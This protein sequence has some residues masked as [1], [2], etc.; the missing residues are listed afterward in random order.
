MHQL[1]AA[2]GPLRSELLCMPR[3]STYA[4]P[5]LHAPAAALLPPAVAGDRTVLR[6]ARRLLFGGSRTTAEA[7]ARTLLGTQDSYG[8]VD[9][10]SR[11]R[12]R[13]F[14]GAQTLVSCSATL[15][16]DVLQVSAQPCMRATPSLS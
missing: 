16:S 2:E 1:T 9:G 13:L 8:G 12:Y 10:V 4:L 15:C 3:P 6:G 5:E 14:A 7:P 11:A